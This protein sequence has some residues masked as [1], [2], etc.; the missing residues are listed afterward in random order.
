VKLDWLTAVTR[1]WLNEQ[2]AKRPHKKWPA[3]KKS[4]KG[5][6]GKRGC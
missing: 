6:G 4:G 5:K 3:M 1:A 2:A